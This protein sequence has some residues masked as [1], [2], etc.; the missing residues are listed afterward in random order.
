MTSFAGYKELPYHLEFKRNKWM[1]RV[2]VSGIV[3]REVPSGE[4]PTA[5]RA[6]EV[7]ERWGLTSVS[8]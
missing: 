8:F 2:H 4:H 3:D 6:A 1:A 7:A 5:A